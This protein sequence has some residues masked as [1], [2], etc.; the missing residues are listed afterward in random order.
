ML[1]LEAEFPIQSE[2][3]CAKGSQSLSSDMKER[4]Q[5]IENE[6]QFLVM[7]RHC[8]SSLDDPPFGKKKFVEILRRSDATLKKQKQRTSD[9]TLQE[10]N[11]WET[12]CC[13][14][15]QEIQSYKKSLWEDFLV[16]FDCC[17]YC[18][19]SVMKLLKLIRYVVVLLPMMNDKLQSFEKKPINVNLQLQ[20]LQKKLHLLGRILVLY[21]EHCIREFR[22]RE[23]LCKNIG[24]LGEWVWIAASL[25]LLNWALDEKDEKIATKLNEYLSRSNR[26]FNKVLLDVTRTCLSLLKDTISSSSDLNFKVDELVSRFKGFQLENLREYMAMDDIQL[27]CDG[28]ILLTTFFMDLPQPEAKG[29]AALDCLITLVISLDF[30]EMNDPSKQFLHNFLEMVDSIQAEVRKPHAII[31][32]FPNYKN[33][34]FE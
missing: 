31:S 13:E 24:A 27:L 32:S 4:I 1:K 10:V 12:L 25:Y 22:I 5:N 16:F 18:S 20:S 3:S 7:Y 28:V 26:K 33:G 6:V 21:S 30:A 8:L 15:V 29:Y 2:L 17:Y 23:L 9:E 14:L 11:S 34:Y 19:F